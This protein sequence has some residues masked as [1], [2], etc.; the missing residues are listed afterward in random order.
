MTAVLEDTPVN[1]ANTLWHASS[2]NCRTVK[3]CVIIHVIR[4]REKLWGEGIWVNGNWG[5]RLPGESSE[6]RCG[7]DFYQAHVDIHMHI[8][9]VSHTHT[10]KSLIIS[11]NKLLCL[12]ESFN[13][14][15]CKN[16]RPRG[17]SESTPEAV[18]AEWT[19]CEPSWP[20]PDTKNPY[21]WPI[22]AFCS[23]ALLYQVL[24]SGIML[25]W[26]YIHLHFKD[27]SFI[28]DLIYLYIF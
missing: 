8:F 27:P 24:A 14:C 23:P 13:K 20:A 11:E 15:N 28:R 25:Q 1:N 10:V 19:W 26:F 22:V 17:R 6:T 3:T 18:L 9:I 12:T 4:R 7:S 5:L 16:M 2:H 21:T